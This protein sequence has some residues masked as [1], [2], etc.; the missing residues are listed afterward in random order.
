MD[1]SSSYLGLDLPHPL[2]VGSSPLSNDLGILRQ[3]AEAGA[4]A[5][6]V[7]SLFEEQ[8][9]DEAMAEA[10]PIDWSSIPAA[11]T[12]DCLP[13]LAPFACTADEYLDKIRE[14]KRAVDIPV[15][16]SLNGTT[17]RDWLRYAPLIEKAGA[18]ALELAVFQI[19]TDPG[20][21]AGELEKD[22][23]HMVMA[24]KEVVAIPLSLKLSPFYTSLPHF[25][26]KLDELGV[27]GLVL[28]NRFFHPDLDIEAMAVERRMT[29]S[30]ASDLLLRLRWLAIL[31]ACERRYDLA[32]SGG[33]YSAGDAVKAILCGADAVQ[34]VSAVLAYGPACLSGMLDG[35]RGWLDNHG[36]GSLR[37]MKG[38]MDRKHCPNAAAFERA[39]YVHILQ[40]WD[41]EA[42]AVPV[43]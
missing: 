40:S 12:L 37:E 6:V 41:T 19:P 25:A 21:D 27:E 17:S 18:D 2:M 11:E 22:V 33:V 43:V 14:I 15:I 42:A 34:V 31:S 29:L 3:C 13:P 16:G 8:V 26:R 28:F 35:L 24:I 9:M 38:L 32:V 20:A 39:N 23:L 7:R 1:L 30:R 5:I 36:T 10:D 4:A